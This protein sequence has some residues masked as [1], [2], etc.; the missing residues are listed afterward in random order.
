MTGRT[1]RKRNVDAFGGSVS[2]S[3]RLFPQDPST[4]ATVNDKT[5]WKG[6]CEIESE[7]VCIF[8]MASFFV[9]QVCSKTS[10]GFFQC[11]AQTV[12]CSRRQGAR[13]GFLRR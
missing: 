2:S 1:T 10:L 5:N 12:W 6:F 9:L 11:N 8:A 7:P 3:P 4:P 13:G